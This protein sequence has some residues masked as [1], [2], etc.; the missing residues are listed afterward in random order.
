MFLES[1]IWN[2]S[3]SCAFSK[4]KPFC[5]LF[6]KELPFCKLLKSTKLFNN[7]FKIFRHYHRGGNIEEAISKKVFPSKDSIKA[8]KAFLIGK[9]TGFISEVTF[10]LKS[11][12]TPKA[13]WREYSGREHILIKQSQPNT[14]RL[15]DFEMLFLL[16]TA[17]WQWQAFNIMNGVWNSNMT[18]T[19][20]RDLFASPVESIFQINICREVQKC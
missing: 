14:P 13:S 10:H 5:E 4:E 3:Y 11:N 20:L 18:R 16:T 2:K 6:Q 8:F 15:V 7:F 17:R 12:C 1:F 9:A 19:K